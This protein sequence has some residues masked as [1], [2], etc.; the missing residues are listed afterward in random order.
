[1]FFFESESPRRRAGVVANQHIQKPEQYLK[2]GT[3]DS[4]FLKSSFT[5]NSIQMIS[6]YVIHIP[7][8]KISAVREVTILS[9]EQFQTLSEIAL[10]LYALFNDLDSM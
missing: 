10:R 1:L 3:A 4:H 2:R 7:D 5:W 8:P 6:M 9:T